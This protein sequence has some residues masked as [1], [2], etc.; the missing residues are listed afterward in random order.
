MHIYHGGEHSTP[1]HLEVVVI[2]I[3]L[4]VP[5]PFFNL[6]NVLSASGAKQTDPQQNKLP[7]HP[8]HEQ[9]WQHLG[10]KSC[11]SAGLHAQ[12]DTHS[13]A[14][15]QPAQQM[16]HMLTHQQS[17]RMHWHIDSQYY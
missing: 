11:S 1:S 15:C 14:S 8:L 3:V 13:R 9:Q 2:T 12:Q 16:P 5:D 17:H 7:P 4:P 6:L 10:S